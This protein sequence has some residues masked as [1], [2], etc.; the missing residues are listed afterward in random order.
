MSLYAKIEE[1]EQE[2]TQIIEE[3]EKG[4]PK[5]EPV[6][7]ADNK[8]DKVKTEEKA[9]EAK[10]D[11]EPKK[12]T[13]KPDAEAA[14][15]AA[16]FARLRREQAAE[17]RRADAL[18]A[19]LKLQPKAAEVKKPETANDEPDPNADPEAHLR[20]ELAQ[21]KA[22]LKDVADWKAQQ[23]QKEQRTA[24]RDNAI[25]AF[26][27]Y[28]EG[29]KP[30][31]TDYE[32]VMNHG[33]SAITASI[34]TLN[35]M[36]KGEALG[37]AIKMQILRLAG[38]AEAAGHD[39]AEYLYHQAKSWGY[40][41]KAADK[42]ADEEKKKPDLKSIVDHKKKSASS[43]S[44]GGKGGNAPLSREAVLDKSF[45]LADFARLTPSQLRELESL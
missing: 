18:E 21:T 37:D 5:D 16:A 12:E 23:T 17:K 24:L 1:I 31:V 34:R 42:P 7:K 28:E 2:E 26:E 4:A 41:P 45:G 40:R 38:Q 14:P 33:I 32:E 20:W 6:E 15:D 39:P 43:L 30:T 8:A 25:K 35:P 36:L 11:A 10:E 9:P 3:I 27:S 19:Q 22:Q 29:F 44:P 13:D